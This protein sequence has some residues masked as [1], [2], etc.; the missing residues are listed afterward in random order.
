MRHIERLTPAR[1]A[2]GIAAEKVVLAAILYD[3]KHYYTA[4]SILGKGYGLFFLCG[5]HITLYEAILKVLQDFPVDESDLM[6][7]CPGGRDEYQ[8]KFHW[9]LDDAFEEMG[10][11]RFSTDQI[12]E[13]VGG[14]FRRIVRFPESVV[15]LTPWAE[16]LRDFTD[17]RLGVKA[18][19]ASNSRPVGS[20]RIPHTDYHEYIGSDQWREKATMAKEEAGRRCQVC[21]GDERL[22]AHHR[23]YER[24]G[25]E[26]KGDL[27]VLCRDCHQVFH[28]NG[29]LVKT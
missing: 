15:D 27:T 28:D 4:S 19:A 9:Q 7:A 29:R 8:D 26:E 24:L 14:Q 23:T 25:R 21:N 17:E 22:E 6:R 16:I 11:S 12:V 2:E 10:H 13:S 20:Q 1:V 3:V 5:P 18:P